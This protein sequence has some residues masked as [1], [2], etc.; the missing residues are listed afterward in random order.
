MV[1]SSIRRPGGAAPSEAGSL[2]LSHVSDDLLCHVAGA[3]HDPFR[4]ASHVALASTSRGIR[5][6]LRHAT[7][8]L[9]ALHLENYV[10]EG[11][12]LSLPG[13]P[14]GASAGLNPP[15]EL[16]AS[17]RVLALTAEE[18]LAANYDRTA[19]L[20]NNSQFPIVREYMSIC[21]GNAT[22]LPPIYFHDVQRRPGVHRSHRGRRGYGAAE[23]RPP[24]PFSANGRPRPRRA[25]RRQR[26]CAQHVTTERRHR[27]RKYL[28]ISEDGAAQMHEQ[29]RA[30]PGEWTL[31]RSYCINRLAKQ[32]G[33]MPLVST[34]CSFGVMSGRH[35]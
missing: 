29:A 25:A 32:Y 16:I 30:Q 6:A 21:P 9:R 10:H 2:S 4:P 7:R 3:L 15:H 33:R 8:S 28:R 12:R 13:G 22:D 1:E 14:D 31:L 27:C 19:T 17:A 20:F 24:E 5:A 34:N 18:L 23:R 35:H 26:Q 11:G